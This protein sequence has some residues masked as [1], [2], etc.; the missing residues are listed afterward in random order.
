VDAAGAF[1]P[2]LLLQAIDAGVRPVIGTI[3]SSE[4]TL[5]MIDEAARL[6][7][8]GAVCASTFCIAET[9]FS[10][11]SRAVGGFLKD[12]DV[13]ERVEVLER[14]G[15]RSWQARPHLVPE[16]AVDHLRVS[17]QA[18]RLSGPE[19]WQEISFRWPHE[20]LTFRHDV[21]GSEAQISGLSRAI[22]KVIE[23]GVVGLLR[24]MET[25]L[26]LNERDRSVT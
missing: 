15:A 10:Y 2:D 16:L 5:G 18:L 20:A 25:V 13:I 1:L 3:G 22:H 11:M 23:P 9:L 7:G 17:A 24:G 6:R 14:S 21:C 4:S 8:I 26:G 12:I 19:G